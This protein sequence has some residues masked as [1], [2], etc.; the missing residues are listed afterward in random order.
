M[1]LCGK[2]EKIG[3]GVIALLQPEYDGTPLESPILITSTSLA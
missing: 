2:T 3:A 1:I